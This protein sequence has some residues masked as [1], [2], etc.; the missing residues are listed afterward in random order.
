M[1]NCLALER[2]TKASA[3]TQT[4]APALKAGAGALIGLEENLQAQLHVESFTGPD[5]GGA[6]EVADGV[7]DDAAAWT[8]SARA[9]GE[10]DAIER[11]N[12]STRN[13]ALTRSV[14]GMFLN[15]DKSTAEYPGP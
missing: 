8:C 2:R 9:R 15:T 12:N 7:V 6:V 10:V 5:A 1:E 11:L 13:W 4:K 3:P 14:I